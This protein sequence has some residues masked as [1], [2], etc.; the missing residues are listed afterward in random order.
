MGKMNFFAD[1]DVLNCLL[2][3]QYDMK[4]QPAMDLTV[5]V[6]ELPF[7]FSLK[8]GETSRSLTIYTQMELYSK[9]EEM[10]VSKAS[11]VLDDAS[12][13]AKV[14]APQGLGENMA[15]FYIACRNLSLF[16]KEKDLDRLWGGSDPEQAG[17]LLTAKNGSLNW[18]LVS[19]A[20]RPELTVERMLG[21]TVKMRP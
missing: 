13:N 11:V 15:A 18:K 19:G 1:L 21:G 3:M 7:W 12:G 2:S 17:I 10:A 6:L 4:A 5:D 9:N 20:E 14:T 8:N 16:A